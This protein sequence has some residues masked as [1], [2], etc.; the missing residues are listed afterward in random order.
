MSATDG[1]P[2][3]H[4]DPEQVAQL[5]AEF[6]FGTGYKRPPQHTQF[7]KGRSGNPNGR[8]R[9]AAADLS[10]AEQPL[11]QKVLEAMG[12]PVT[13]REGDKVRTISTIDATIQA[14][15]VA[16]LKGNARMTGLL[17]DRFQMAS[18]A[19]AREIKERNAFWTA[20]KER[21]TARLAEAALWGQ[22][23]P[24]ILPHPDDIV[25][26]SDGPRCLGPIDDEEQKE[27]EEKIAIRN[28]LIM[29]EVLDQRLKT[30]SRRIPKEFGGAMLYAMLLEHG[31]PPRLRLSEME[32]ARRYSVHRTAT[33]RQLLKDVHRG[34][35]RLGA[36]RRRGAVFPERRIVEKKLQ[37]M[38][39]F[40]TAAT[41]GA[42]NINAIAR[43]QFDDDLLDFLEEHGCPTDA[44][45]Q[46]RDGTSQR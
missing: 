16:A 38:S 5:K 40:V 22:P 32:M 43:G 4:L 15:G 14:A 33:K 13:V 3:P 11:M 21:N 18:E 39:D 20:Y 9:R 46:A 8:P 41:S 17:L 42:I 10:L 19:Q 36:P 35:T 44:F 2:G 27:L 45:V 37:L 29:Q 28:L 7:Q 25:I 12:K 24:Q 1:K 31:I 23:A 34:W 26:T 6:L 30:R